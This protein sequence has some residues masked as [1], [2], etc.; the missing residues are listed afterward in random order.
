MQLGQRAAAEWRYRFDPTDDPER[1]LLTGPC[2]ECRDVFE[3]DWPLSVVRSDVLP[4]VNIETRGLLIPVIC[5]CKVEH[6]GADGEKGC[7]RSWMM[8]VRE[9]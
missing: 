6:P 2:P 5:R 4:E 1:V 7:G 9:P 3:Y 8:T